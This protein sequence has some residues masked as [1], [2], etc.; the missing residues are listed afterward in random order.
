M[1]TETMISTMVR[2]YNGKHKS[3]VCSLG[4][5]QSIHRNVQIFWSKGGKG[6]RKSTKNCITSV[7]TTNM[8]DYNLCTETVKGIDLVILAL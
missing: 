7:L 8:E 1:K 4:E 3:V 2:S 6:R 5:I